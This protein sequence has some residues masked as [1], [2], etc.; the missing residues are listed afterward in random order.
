MIEITQFG[1][2]GNDSSKDTS[3]PTPPVI[4]DLPEP[5]EASGWL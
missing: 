4:I 5:E 3:P 2:M 1:M